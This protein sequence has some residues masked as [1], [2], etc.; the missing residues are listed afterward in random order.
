MDLIKMTQDKNQQIITLVKQAQNNDTQALD[1]LFKLFSRFR[2]KIYQRYA[3]KGVANKDILQAI[4]LSFLEGVLCYDEGKF[5]NAIIFLTRKIQNDAWTF[6]R[7]EMYY[8]TRYGRPILTDDENLLEPKRALDEELIER[9]N[10]DNVV[11]VNDAVSNLSDVEKQ[12]LHWC[13]WDCLTYREIGEKLGG[14]SRQ[15]VHQRLQ[16]ILQKMKPY[17]E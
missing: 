5:D 13:F 14:V 7:K 8:G 11:I 15:A 6:Y 17:L 9:E 3:F 16:L 2:Y 4:N 10:I 12:I 1:K